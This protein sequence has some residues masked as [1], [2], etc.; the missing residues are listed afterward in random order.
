MA[1]KRLPNYSTI[2]LDMRDPI[3]NRGQINAMSTMYARMMH[4]HYIRHRASV[5][6]RQRE[7]IAVYQRHEAA[8]EAREDGILVIVLAAMT[9]ESAVNAMGVH[10]FPGKRFRDA[11]HPYSLRDTWQIVMKNV[12]GRG[13]RE[14]GP[15]YQ[16][17]RH[18]AE[19]RNSLVHN[20]AKQLEL[21]D[22]QAMDQAFAQAHPAV[23]EGKVKQ[24]FEAV[25]A[26]SYAAHSMTPDPVGKPVLLQSYDL[27][28][29]PYLEEEFPAD[30]WAE[31]VAVRESMSDAEY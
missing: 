2:N 21:L 15:A 5:M 14:K 11:V 3:P 24:A 12:F 13:F 27:G 10:Y 23:L 26:V 4:K 16:A 22:Q 9:L 20:H 17:M 18:L 31:I 8:R 29:V 7:D 25:V 6:E 28:R 30:I 19:A 1:G